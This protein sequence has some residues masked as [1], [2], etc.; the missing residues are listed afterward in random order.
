MKKIL[1]GLAIVLGV[2]LLILILIPVFFKDRIFEEVD[3]QLAKS[4]N[5][6]V[7]YDA[8]EVSL[9]LL[10]HFPNLT[11]GLQDF[12]IVGN[13]PFEGDTLVSA[14][15]FEITLDLGSV[16]FGDQMEIKNLELENPF[17][18]ILVLEDGT[19]NYDIAIAEE[20][21]PGTAADTASTAFNVG[22]EGWKVTNGRLIYEDKSLPFRLT[23]DE[24]THSGS[25]D[26]TQDIFELTTFTEAQRGSMWY[27]GV[28][29][30]SDKHL[31]ADATLEMNLPESKYTFRDNRISLND[32][33]IQLDGWIAMPNDPI[34]FDLTFDAPENSFKSLLSLVPGMYSESFDELE[35]SG[36]VA[37]TGFLK[38]RMDEESMPG[39]GLN[40]QVN[41]GEFRYPDL[42]EAVRNVQLNMK[43]EDPTGDMKNLLVDL[44][45]L[46]LDMGN[47]PVKA[48]MRLEGLQPMQLKADVDAR[49]NLAELNQMLKIDTLTMKGLF[50]LNL[51][52]EGIYD[53]VANRF[54]NTN[55]KMQLENGYFKTAGY[56]VPV[57]DVNLSG[58]VSN[59]NG[60]ME[61]TQ[62]QIPAF[63]FKVGDDQMRGSL[64][65]QNLNDY[66]WDAAI[67]G[68]LDLTTI[69]KIVE[70]EDME[71]AGRIIADIQS[72]GRMSALDAGQYDRLDTRG[73]MAVQDF[74]Y[75]S[76]DLPYDFKLSKAAMTFTPKAMQLSEFAGQI[77]DTDLNLTG[78]VQNYLGYALKEDQT[79]YGDFALQSRRVNLNEWMSEEEAAEADTTAGEISPIEI[80]QN[81]DLRFTAK[82]DEVLY[83][84]L[85][86]QNMA[87]TI[88]A[89]DGVLRMD[90][91]TF[92]TLGGGFGLSGSYD[93]REIKKPKFD[94]DFK[95]QD[96]SIKQAYQNFVTIQKLAPIAEKVNG[97]FSTNFSLNGLLGEDMMPNI[98]SLSGQ[99]IVEI[100][101]ATLTNSNLL[102]KVA[103]VTNLNKVSSADAVMLKD[104]LL[105][106]KVDDGGVGVDPFDFSIGDID[107]T[108]GGRQGIDGSLDYK[109][110][111]E[112]PAGAAGQAINNLL[113]KI[114]QGPGA[115]VQTV[116]L[117]LAVGGTYN[118]PA[119]KLVGG[120]SSS[121]GG[122]EGI[123]GS[124]TETAKEA[125]K[126][127]LQEEMNDAKAQLE[128]ERKAA[129]EKAK[130][131]LEAKRAEAEA[132]ARQELERKK[133]AV[134]D[135]LKKK[136]RNVLKDLL[137][138][139][140]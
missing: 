93:P 135:S 121:S 133:K 52:A 88:T 30:V 38:G 69:Q 20:E 98:A 43:V 11:A 14:D 42:P 137:K 1:L 31:T 21:L 139:G 40:L 125:A 12:S 81:L 97:T 106:V 82:I 105:K 129:E 110:A 28:E 130:A 90:G 67:A 32:F 27:D 10:R 76:A 19:A 6:Q 33:G 91:L 58:T 26:F 111:L 65:L 122:A 44:S 134:E 108:L 66:Q 49:L 56:D 5:A 50:S 48:S 75:A 64:Q 96:L 123:V 109:M 18:Q 92:N 70:F 79:L 3:K 127:K 41:N 83:D 101:Q 138:D 103:S 36:E 132:Q 77:G 84:N 124:V 46:Q 100:L 72:K 45:T 128:A 89:K 73:S 119:V 63:A 112:V 16:L 74:L 99:G 39:Y 54:P 59:Q 115:D 25:G 60:S 47:N 61:A 114:G 15:A 87:G 62:I 120:G 35:A 71:M 117:N 80:P 17:I 23:L 78:S 57:Q 107:A 13:A 104:L 136:S 116:N 140:K 94:I 4:I 85:N 95:I 86:L 9:S 113:A 131:E 53:S 7:Y 24:I 34:D 68:T 29:Y 126:E 51:K 55:A 8:D 118:D 22:I 102:Q 2:F 37:F